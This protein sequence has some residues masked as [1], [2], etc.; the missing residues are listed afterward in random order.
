MEALFRMMNKKGQPPAIALLVF[1]I[2]ILLGATLFSFY[3]SSTGVKENLIDARFVESVYAEETQA[4][5]DMITAGGSAIVESYME[6]VADNPF[7]KSAGELNELMRL[8]ISEKFNSN[9]VIKSNYPGIAFE[10]KVDGANVNITSGQ[11]RLETSGKFG[12]SRVV[13]VLYR[14]ILEEKFNL[15]DY[16]LY[17]LAYI[18][19]SSAEC[20]SMKEA[21]DVNKC[22][23]ER[24]PY[25]SSKVF[26]SGGKKSVQFTTEKYYLISQKFE[27]IEFSLA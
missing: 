8:K 16:G 3:K 14:T 4:R 10:V 21:V 17:D 5:F 26:E 13:G 1:M 22:F 6:I 18:K 20:L 24:L 7:D 15:E 9:S 2:V 23:S 11:I 27:D 25:L 19:F 12:G